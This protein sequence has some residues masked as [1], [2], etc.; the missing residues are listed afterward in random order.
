MRP[1][2]RVSAWFESGRIVRPSAEE[3]NFVDAV[4]ALALLAGS[5]EAAAGR[6]ASEIAGLIGEHERYLFVLID[7]MGARQLDALPGDS[8][9]RSNI[10]REIQTVFLSTTSSVLTTLS[11]GRWPCE[12][13]VPGWWTYLDDLGISCVPLPFVERVSG[14][15][16]DEL[17]VRPE[18][19]FTV[20]SIWPSFG[21]RPVSIVPAAIQGSI[22]SNYSSGGTESLGYDDLESAA[23]L[24]RE[25]VLEA[26]APSLTYLYLPQY[27][28]LVHQKG[29]R[30]EETIHLLS[31]MDRLVSGLAAS[32]G[33]RARIIVTADHGLADTPKEHLL[34]MKED[35]PL[36]DM[37]LVE[38]TGERT[39]PIFHVRPG[40]EGEFAEAFDARFG[41][42]FSLL[43]PDEV[44]EMKLLGPGALS[45]VMRGRLGTYV[46][47][48][49]YSAQLYVRH[50]DGG[51]PSFVGVHGG[52]TLDEMKIPFILA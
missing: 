39:V 29:T 35:D 11:T 21:H 47:V 30:D 42:H 38:P 28:S 24:A 45:P 31:D 1:T 20:P 12:H 49:P 13:G 4:H 50:P 2:E 5:P 36:L 10:A 15:R 51:T 7:G 48:A 25:N 19:V 22:Y 9:L 46:G 34:E 3:T 23:Y 17:G 8:F 43:T 44:E 27:D 33:G 6:G 37:L 32:L 40:S 14:R 41:E 26:A 16:L 52:L 18:Q